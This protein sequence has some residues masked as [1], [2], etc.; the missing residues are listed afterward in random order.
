MK[1]IFEIKKHGMIPESLKPL[2]DSIGLTFTGIAT[3]LNI[4]IGFLGATF[5]GF[6][7]SPIFSSLLTIVISVL[8]I[9]WIIMKIY[10]QYLTTKLKK[11]AM[12]GAEPEK[13]KAFLKSLKKDE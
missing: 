3:Y 8:S 1:P 9:L 12:A 4:K 5:S 13:N 6:L 11:E 10:D 2:T 7:F